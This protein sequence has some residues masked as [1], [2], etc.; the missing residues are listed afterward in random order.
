MFVERSHLRARLLVAVKVGQ[1][2]IAQM[3]FMV[4]LCVSLS[5]ANE[6]TGKNQHWQ[7]AVTE[8]AMPAANQISFQSVAKGHRS[9]VRESLQIV[10][11]NQVEWNALWQK[12]AAVELNPM[13]SPAINFDN[14]IVVGVFLGEKRSGGY[15]TEIIRVEQTDDVLYI[16]Y[17]E[18][19]PLPGQISAQG[20]TQPFH[21]AR[22]P[23]K[24]N[25]KVVFRRTS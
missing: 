25:S 18:R 19:S 4:M 20:L 8:S 1:R 17:G 7:L 11:R 15:A 10:A 13:P 14:E 12:H 16:Y 2:I 5:D 22:I 23:S 3:L 9:G 6:I 24:A 21:I